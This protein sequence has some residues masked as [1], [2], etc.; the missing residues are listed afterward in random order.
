MPL[1]LDA[2]WR[3][4]F[5][6]QS[7]ARRSDSQLIVRSRRSTLASEDGAQSLVSELR[8]QITQGKL[9][10]GD[11][12]LPLRDLARQY[13]ISF[14][15][16]RAAISRLEEHNWVYRKDRSGT[17]VSDQPGKPVA[18]PHGTGSR[19]A[20]HPNDARH[21]S[22]CVGLM[23]NQTGHV[24]GEMAS[25]LIAGVN[26]ASLETATAAIEA[27]QRV[28]DIAHVI[29]SWRANPPRAVVLQWSDVPGLDEE[30]HRALSGRCRLIA[31]MRHA[32]EKLSGWHCVRADY[33]RAM[34]LA[35]DLLCSEG[36]RRLGLMIH[37]RR[38]T[39]RAQSLVRKRESGQVGT[40]QA[41][42]Q[43][44]RQRGLKNAL[45]IFYDRSNHHG[46][47]D[48]S[49]P[50]DIAS[51]VR[52]LRRPDRPT[53][54][55]AQ[56]S[57]IVLLIQAARQLGLRIPEDIRLLG[58]GNTPWAGAFGFQSIRLREDTIAQEVL[59]LIRLD[60]DPAQ[61]AARQVLVPPELPGSAS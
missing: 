9:R 1:R 7:M 22:R 23:M 30:L 45:S 47:F 56:D 44:L 21:G 42:G 2:T 41:L 27:P 3:M 8:S 39:S 32:P 20:P 38:A 15:T 37:A 29:A 34:M 61:E 49:S 46:S 40:I 19:N 10:P 16:A 48:P 25:R 55:V 36:H 33:T 24:V 5:T 13:G 12:V 26:A 4:C 35:S 6:A 54:V 51:V 31:A 52:W 17:F 11:R 18:A 43:A 50:Q 59:N 58:I 60:S 53:A 57:R 14:L 28:E